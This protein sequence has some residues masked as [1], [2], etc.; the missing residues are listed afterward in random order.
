MTLAGASVVNWTDDKG[1]KQTDVSMDTN[2]LQNP[3]EIV[4]V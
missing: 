4:I 3:L 1:M 2:D